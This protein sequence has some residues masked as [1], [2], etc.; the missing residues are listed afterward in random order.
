MFR[1]IPDRT[2]DNKRGHEF[3]R[4]LHDYLFK[5]WHKRIRISAGRPL[6]ELPAVWYVVRL[7]PKEITFHLATSAECETFLRQ[8]V[9][10]YWERSAIMDEP[11]DRVNPLHTSA[12]ELNYAR[13]NIFAL[14]ADWREDTVPI[15][16]ILNVVRDMKDGDEAR[17]VIRISPY[18]RKAWQDWSDRAWDEFKKGKTPHRSVGG[19]FNLKQLAAG[20][21]GQLQGMSEL[22]GTIFDGSIAKEVDLSRKKRHKADVEKREIM[23]DGRLQR[24]T[25][26]KR[27]EPVFRT[28]IYVLSH[29]EDI[30]RRQ[31]TLRAL[32]NAF[33]ELSGD[34]ELKRREYGRLSTRGVD[35]LNRWETFGHSVDN[36]MSCSETGKLFQLPTASLQ[37]EFKD[38]LATIERRET[39]LNE[40]LAKAKI[41]M[42][43]VTHRGTTQAWGFPISNHDELCLP[44]VVIGGMGVGKTGSYGGNFGA[45]AL[46]CGFSVFS[47]DVAKDGLGEEIDIGAR[48]LGVS[49]DK[50]IHL[51]FGEMAIRLDWPEASHGKYAANRLAGEVLNF[52]NLHGHEA[53]VETARLIR[54]A[55]KTLGII[56]G[57]L[58]DM[59]MLFT[60][61][62]YRK[63]AVETVREARP[64]LYDEWQTFERLSDGMKGRV[65]EPVLNRLDM[66]LG[67]DYLRECFQC[68]E[69]IDFTQYMTGGYHV[70][71]H[72]PKRELGAETTDILVDFLMSKIELA[73]FA[74]AEEDQVPAFV[75]ADEPHQFK[76][77]APRW[78]RMAVES[79]KWRLGLIFMF[80]LWDQVP[81]TLTNSIKAAGPHYTIYTTSKQILRDL[82]EEIDP[83][84]VEEALKTPRHYAINVI[85]AGGETVTPFIS[86]MS[87]PPSEWKA[88][89]AEND[90]TG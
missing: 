7:T 11:L 69:G 38:Y 27:N 49:S 41:A 35:A 44:R 6:S 21:D 85:R 42:G 54:L 31:I 83:F 70:R 74:R 53:G 88:D 10:R 71:I 28:H 60:D 4:A 72:V 19:R 37:D 29:S 16:S 23:Q 64:D 33:T 43:T 50:R 3:T 82:A 78:E 12:A 81:K 40:R 30:S 25:M 8:R 1:I 48:S 61:P 87:A 45:G 55:A 80:H 9:A 34:N 79:R 89:R 5:P 90:A 59:M 75:I 52:F 18:S 46:A 77:C 15:T 65:L 14:A 24:E 32:S 26:Q 67:D 86:K 36:L 76:S 17:V 62:K 63:N 56:G 68:L 2:V 39:G 73:M 13:H 20:L 84:T 51:R 22:V 47:I 66:L 57:S 58:Y